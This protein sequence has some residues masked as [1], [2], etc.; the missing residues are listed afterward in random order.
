MIR[1]GLYVSS[2]YIYPVDTAS[3][4]FA[5]ASLWIATSAF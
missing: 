3:V 2:G 1:V 5:I 4:F